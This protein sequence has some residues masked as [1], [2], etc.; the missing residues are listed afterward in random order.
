MVRNPMAPGLADTIWS[1]SIALMPP[2]A[3][4]GGPTNRLVNTARPAISPSEYR[5]CTS[6]R[7][8]L[9]APMIGLSGIGPSGTEKSPGAHVKPE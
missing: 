4:P 8:G 7:T 1:P 3:Y 9:H 6:G 2:C 5:S